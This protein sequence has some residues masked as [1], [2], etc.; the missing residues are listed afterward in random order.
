M[1]L[2]LN[3][4]NAVI[5]LLYLEGRRVIRWGEASLPPGLVKDG[6]VLQPRAVGETVAALLKEKKMPRGRAIACLTG[7]TFTYRF[8]TLP[9]MKAAF[10]DEAL[11][12]AAR[13]E[14]PLPL[15]ELYLSWQVV[16]MRPNEVDYFVA[17]VARHLVDALVQ[18][19]EAAAIEPYTMDLKPL[20]LAR[21]AHR[22]EAIVVSFEPDYFDIVVVARGIPTILH[23]ASPR[24]AGATL[25]DNTRQLVDELLKT[26]AF[27]D[28]HHPQEPLP[29]STPVLLTGA[30]ASRANRTGLIQSQ[31][32]YP[33]AP[34]VPPL[35][36]PDDLPLAPY[37]ANMGLALKKIP[38]RAPA[39][40]EATRF[41]D[42]N[43]NILSG[44]YRKPRARPIS[45]KLF[46]SLLFLTVAAVLLFPLYLSYRQADTAATLLLTEFARIDQDTYEA[47]QAL[48]KS[49]QTESTISSI[50]EETGALEQEHAAILAHRGDFPADLQRV[51][52]ALPPQAYFTS[53][54]IAPERLTVQGETDSPFQVVSYA[55]ALEALKR[56]AEVRIIKI[57]ETSLS[58]SGENGETAAEE[59]KNVITFVIAVS[60]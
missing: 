21:A 7:L 30:L 4:S 58:P 49:E 22:G 10:Q 53:I 31:V 35:P 41:H 34:L 16:S 40:G 29:S 56:Y 47:Q 27:Y 44:K 43:V 59:T 46:L 38:P 57:D 39:R 15:E 9:R 25:E 45:S 2:T 1:S 51:T 13:K 14:I 19:L 50:L 8:L 48:K 26:A 33:V 54:D 23:T 11:E 42:I 6:L 20:A 3:I 28:S 36:V 18:T 5:R 60:R 32:A 37:A 52:A 24:W 17:G 12:R 55:L